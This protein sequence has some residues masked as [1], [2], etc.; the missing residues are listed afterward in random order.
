[1]PDDF[2]ICRI[3]EGN[4]VTIPVSRPVKSAFC[5]AFCLFQNI[6]RANTYFFSFDDS[7]ELT[8]YEK[9]IVCRAVGGGVF[10]D[11]MMIKRRSVQTF[12][13]FNDF[14]RRLEGF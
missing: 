5:V 2:T 4:P 13:M 7:Q 6:L 1:M 3:K 12:P 10:F 8:F 11:G 14:P 9:G